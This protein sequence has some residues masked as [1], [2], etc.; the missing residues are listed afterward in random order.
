[1]IQSGNWRGEL[2]PARELAKSTGPE[3]VPAQIPPE[4]ELWSGPTLHTI[5]NY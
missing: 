1:M 3:P 4:P 5:C 2:D